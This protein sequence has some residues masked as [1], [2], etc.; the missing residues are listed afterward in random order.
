[1][2]EVTL[3]KEE[4]MEMRALSAEIQLLE[5]QARQA[6]QA[7]QDR[8]NEIVKLWTERYGKLVQIDF[9]RGTML[10]EAENNGKN[11]AEIQTVLADS[12]C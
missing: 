4:I 10:I 12:S 5:M 1:M 7:K 3:P 6:L 8:R 2:Q 11:R 9:E